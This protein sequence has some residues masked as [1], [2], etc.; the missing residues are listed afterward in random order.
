VVS[1]QI[2]VSLRDFAMTGRFGPVSLGVSRPQLR[3]LLG[4]PDDCGCAPCTV[5]KA[6]IW[7]YGDVEFHFTSKSATAAVWLIFSDA[8]EQR[9]VLRSG[10]RVKLLNW[11]L[12]RR[13]SRRDLKKELR[14]LNVPSVE[15]I[16]QLIPDQIHVKTAA[17]VEFSFLKDAGHRVAG[18]FFAMSMTDPKVLHWRPIPSSVRRWEPPR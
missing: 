2:T 12:H 1:R 4:A 3:R 5:G 7:F 17:G 11:I 9:P 6:K 14:R 13:L 16:S 8:F 10:R 18:R 15:Y